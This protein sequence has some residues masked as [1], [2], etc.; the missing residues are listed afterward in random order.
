M[1]CGRTPGK[2]NRRGVEAAS[3]IAL[4]LRVATH[5]FLQR[6]YARTSLNDVVKR[7]GGSKATVRKYYRN[8]AGLFAAVIADVSAR[9]VASAHLQDIPGAPEQV[10]RAFGRTVLTFYLAADSLAC[11]RGVVAEGHA[12]RVMAQAF[13]RQGHQLVQS[14]LAERLAGWRREG[15]LL[16]GNPMDDANLFLHL[17][18]AGVYEQRLI[19]LRKAPGRREIAARVASA[20]QLFLHGRLGARR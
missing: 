20:V 13:Y 2:G 14:A 5:L 10:L 12:S 17:I 16:G 11:Y 3:R 9:F 7:A 19:G 8:K 1:K 6:G 18:R 4:L 15:R